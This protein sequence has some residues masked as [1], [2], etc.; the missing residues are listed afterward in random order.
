[1]SAILVL[2]LLTACSS[3]VSSG[4]YT[5]VKG[6]TVYTV[7]PENGTIS[8]GTYTYGCDV[9]PNGTGYKLTIT[10]PD[11]STFFW[12]NSGNSGFG[13][14]SEDYDPDR[15]ADGFTLKGILEEKRPVE[16]SSNHGAIAIALMMLGMFQA[17]APRISWYLGYGWR[18]KDAE[19]SDAALALGRGGGILAIVI[20]VILLFV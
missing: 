3:N 16:K 18:Y 7:D 13:G 15:Y 19:P 17:V 8:D 4:S 1:M 10:Y 2:A 5:V 14:W 6:N 9:T 11:G 12:N 20:G